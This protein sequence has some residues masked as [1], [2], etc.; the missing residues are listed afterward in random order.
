MQKKMFLK[1]SEISLKNRCVVAFFKYVTGLQACNFVKKRLFL[2]LR[3]ATLSKK[4]T[5]ALFY[6]CCE[7]SKTAFSTDHLGTAAF[8]SC[9]FEFASPRRTRQLLRYPV[10]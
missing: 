9:V 5:L 1:I 4:E 3:P 7:I 10:R 2:C 8:E 6:E